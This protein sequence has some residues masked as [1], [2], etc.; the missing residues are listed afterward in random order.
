VFGKTDKIYLKQYLQETN[1][2]LICIV[3]ASESMGYGTVR[4]APDARPGSVRR[5]D[6]PRGCDHAGD[7]LRSDREAA[8][9]RVPDPARPPSCGSPPTSPWR[10]HRSTVRALLNTRSTWNRSR[11][12]SRAGSRARCGTSYGPRPRQHWVFRASV[13]P[14]TRPPR[15]SSG[16]RDHA[17]GFFDEAGA[18]ARCG[19]PALRV[20]GLQDIETGEVKS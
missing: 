5:G 7:R 15:G 17:F 4:S 11:V 18:G 20:S 8:S 6:S 9:P 3:D 2:H 14:T 13:I 19:W 16:S 12:Q 1:L 10:R